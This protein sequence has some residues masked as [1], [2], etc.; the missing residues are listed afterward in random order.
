VTRADDDKKSD[1]A[2]PPAP[3]VSEDAGRGPLLLPVGSA[4]TSDGG[5]DQA[6]ATAT[7]AIIAEP[8]A[9]API[10]VAL[11]VPDEAGPALPTTYSDAE[12]RDAVGVSGPVHAPAAAAPPRQARSRHWRDRDDDGAT[13]RG[14]RTLMVAA[15]AITIGIIAGT[16]ALLGRA[17]SERYAI[18]C[19]SDKI[20]AEQGRAFPP[21]GS[22]PLSGTEW[23][24][25]AIAPDAECKPRDTDDLDELAKWYLDLLV[26]QANSQLTAR[27]VTKIDLVAEQLNQ[28]LLLARAP[29]RRDQRKDIERLLGDV[30]Y[31]RASAKLRDAAA[32]LAEA[33]KLFD[34]AAAQRPR[35][36][37][38]A[39]ARASDARKL[40]DELH[41]GPAGTSKT[42]FPPLPQPEHPAA[43]VGAA[44]P[45]EPERGSDAPPPL[46]APDAGVPTGGVLL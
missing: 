7:P 39:A 13:P 42:T 4:P 29:E 2:N 10:D 6:T 37:S 18:K 24:P 23:K 3:L 17:N 44:L 25:I 9:P 11:P 31:W 41:A 19:E 26:D 1:E 33:A 20:V 8:A 14:G 32:A 27:E 40:V 22:R 5:W 43:P 28:A 38:D 35:H 45:I 30:E 46:A 34:S 12:L 36:A 21:W 16:F 15:L